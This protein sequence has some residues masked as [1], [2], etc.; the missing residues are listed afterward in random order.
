MAA[1]TRADRKKVASP[2]VR[3]VI[4]DL[5]E[6]KGL[7]VTDLEAAVTA[8][9]NWI[10]ANQASLVASLPE[11]FKSNTSASAKIRLF[12]YTAMKRGGLL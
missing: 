7:T 6:S 10:A 11:P 1:L 3:T 12:I 8:I 9:D 2:W 4:R 5:G